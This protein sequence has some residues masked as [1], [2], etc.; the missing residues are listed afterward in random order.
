MQ[1]IGGSRLKCVKEMH[2]DGGQ[3]FN[4]DSQQRLALNKT[5]F[6]IATLLLQGKESKD[7]VREVQ[8]KYR[9]TRRKL[10]ESDIDGV[11]KLLDDFVRQEKVATP[12]DYRLHR[13]AGERPLQMPISIYW[14]VTLSCNLRCLHCYTASGA[15]H[16]EELDTPECLALIREWGAG[17]VCEVIIGGGEPFTRPDM[18][19]LIDAIQQAEMSAICVS[20]GTLLTTDLVG[21]LSDTGL[22]YMAV[23]IDGHTPDLHNQFRGTEFAFGKAVQGIQNLKKAGFTVTLQTVV[24]QLNKHALE[25][26]A[27]FAWNLGASS[28]DVKAFNIVNRAAINRQ[29]ALRPEDVAEIASRLQAIGQQYDGRLGVDTTYPMTFTLNREFKKAEKPIRRLACGPGF[30]TA[31]LTADGRL[32]TCSFIRHHDWISKSV[33]EE[34]FT[35]LW[36]TS[37]IFDPF[38]NLTT[39]HLTCCKDCSLLFEECWGGC[40]ARAFASTG[41]FFARDPLCQ[42]C[43]AV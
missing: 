38:R 24:T 36:Q 29:L 13:Y 41:D 7:I 21:R 40:R 25:A 4:L 42:L 14:E 6:L 26:I 5:G 20:N 39:A 35:K 8:R 10:V 12:S 37:P 3:I 9:G 2:A 19:E 22:S 18:V 17:G 28:W 30:E 27:D 1:T 31:G 43:I 15:R 23:S 32:L 11:I 33:R 16:P 34:G